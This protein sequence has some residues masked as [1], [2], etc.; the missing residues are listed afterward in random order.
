MPLIIIMHCYNYDITKGCGKNYYHV[1][2]AALVV[3]CV[4]VQKVVIVLSMHACCSFRDD[5]D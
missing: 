1:I 5:S 4:C 2:S 3:T